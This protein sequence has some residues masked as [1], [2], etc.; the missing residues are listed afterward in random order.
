[1]GFLDWLHP[2]HCTGLRYSDKAQAWASFQFAEPY[3]QIA[4]IV[5]GILCEQTGAEFSEL[6][7]FTHFVTEM[8]FFDFFDPAAYVTAI[9][10]ELQLAI[11]EHEAEKISCISELVE[12]LYTRISPKTMS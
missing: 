6:H 4:A 7:A 1:M 8:I 10:Q 12:Y 9:E 5:A 3:Q 11:P 2:P